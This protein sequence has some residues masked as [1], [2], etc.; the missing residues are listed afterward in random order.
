[1]S[2][3]PCCAITIDGNSVIGK[4]DF[5]NVNKMMII[6]K[7]KTPTYF[8]IWDL[9]IIGSNFHCRV[10]K[11]NCY[12]LLID[13]LLTFSIKNALDDS[14]RSEKCLEKPEEEILDLIVAYS[15]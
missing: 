10:K 2:F 14:H 1:M 6:M 8:A 11:N 15:V 9:P 3:I 12:I 5:D 13:I 4:T 7:P